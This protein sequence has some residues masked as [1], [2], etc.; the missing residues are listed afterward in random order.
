[1]AKPV[2][3]AGSPPQTWLPLIPLFFAA[4]TAVPYRIVGTPAAGPGLD[5]PLATADSF[6]TAY[7]RTT[8]SGG[9]V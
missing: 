4:L 2:W 9:R 8:G 6:V 7:G 1:M 3:I 5:H